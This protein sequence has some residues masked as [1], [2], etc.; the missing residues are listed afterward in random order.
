MIAARP[1]PDIS[2]PWNFVAMD[3]LRR[4]AGMSLR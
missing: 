1:L 3:L 2:A 4:E